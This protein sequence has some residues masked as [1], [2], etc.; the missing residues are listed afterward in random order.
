ML[1]R[2]SSP[3][4]DTVNTKADRVKN[5]TGLILGR[6]PLTDDNHLGQSRFHL[7]LIKITKHYRQ[8]TTGKGLLCLWY[9]LL[10]LLLTMDFSFRAGWA[11]ATNGK[12]CEGVRSKMC[13]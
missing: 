9:H 4:Q 13:N 6:H 11:L 1:R 2:T 10:I 7:Q 12:G 8:G 5:R 3:P